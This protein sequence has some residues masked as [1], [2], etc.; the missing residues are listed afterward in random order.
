MDRIYYLP[1]NCQ[2]MNESNPINHPLCQICGE[3]MV[4]NES[5]HYRS[6]KNIHFFHC[7]DIL[8]DYHKS[9]SCFKL[10]IDM[11]ISNE[12]IKMYQN[13]LSLI[14]KNKQAPLGIDWSKHFNVLCNQHVTYTKN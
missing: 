2:Y 10:K 5:L 4:I 13:E 12:L 3:S 11:E 8:L 7:P 6:N 9:A 14:L 1:F